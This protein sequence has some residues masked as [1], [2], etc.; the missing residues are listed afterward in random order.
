MFTYSW[1]NL[2]KILKKRSKVLETNPDVKCYSVIDEK[3]LPDL[4]DILIKLQN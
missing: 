4:V 3:A 1:T 2:R